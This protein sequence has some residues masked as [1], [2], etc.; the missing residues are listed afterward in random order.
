MIKLFKQA[1]HS[2]QT[3]WEGY[4]KAHTNTWNQ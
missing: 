1:K 3:G 2:V 4:S